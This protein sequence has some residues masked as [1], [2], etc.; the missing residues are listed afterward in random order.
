M[1]KREKEEELRK[2]NYTED[3]ISFSVWQ[4]WSNE[5][6][7]RR[8]REM[9]K[10]VD[11]AWAVA[12]LLD[13]AAMVLG[14]WGGMNGDPAMLTIVAE[15]VDVAAE[16]RSKVPITIDTTT[17]VANLIIQNIRFD[18]NLKKEQ[19]IIHCTCRPVHIL[20]YFYIFACWFNGICT[21]WDAARIHALVVHYQYLSIHL[22]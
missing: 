18:F 3:L 6:A 20:F 12:V 17:F 21:S 11:C 1:R 4:G 2:T 7:W 22:S 19:V 14:P 10:E 16:K 5:W 9:R 15:T 8:T 13:E